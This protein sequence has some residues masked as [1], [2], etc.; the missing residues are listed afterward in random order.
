MRQVPETQAKYLVVG[1]GR[2]ARHVTHY[3]GLLDIPFT[4]YTRHA[5][6]PFASYLSDCNRVL[7]LIRDSEIVNF[8]EQNKREASDSVLWVHCSGV[9]QTDLAVSAHP[10]ASFSGVLFDEPFYRTIPFAIQKGGRSFSEILPGFPNPHFEIE[11]AAK[12]KYHAMCVLAG[13]FST[14]LWMTFEKYLRQELMVPKSFMLP[15]LQSTVTN[16]EQVDD[17]LTGPLKRNDQET[18]RKNLSHLNDPAM[19]D[20]YQAFVKFYTNQ[21]PHEMAM[22]KV[23]PKT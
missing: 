6:G 8:I 9:L 2:L 22:H 1:N 5:T 12:E 15:Y 11:A 13:N 10:L 23:H 7:V 18:I 3:L 20:I 19:K 16:L 21:N 17:P 14:I 4:Q